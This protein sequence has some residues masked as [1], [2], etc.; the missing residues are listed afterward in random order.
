MNH[1]MN[2]I[3]GDKFSH[4]AND[5]NVITI[6]K[7]IQLI[8]SNI[9]NKKLSGEYF[10]GQGISN[11][12]EDVI[13]E[14]IN[15][16][17]PNNLIK[18]HFYSRKAN[19]AITHKKN[20]SNVMISTPVFIS[21]N[22][23]I[24]D[25][26][27]DD[28]CAEMSD[29]VTGCHIQGMILIEAARQMMLSVSEI[30]FLDET[31]KMYFILHDINTVFKGFIFPINVQILYKVVESKKKASGAFYSLVAV[32]FHQANEL[33]T[34]VNIGFTAYSKDFMEKKE[35]ILANKVIIDGQV[36]YKPN[37]IID[38]EVD[39]IN[40]IQPYNQSPYTNANNQMGLR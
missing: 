14:L 28:E 38:Q 17:N 1:L 2:Y 25:L 27:I 30:F 40:S 24:S 23:Y 29:H 8:K 16:Y 3:V 22:L 26:C 34:I 6:S 7:F 9:F 31:Q 13:K 21:N 32:E 20:P 36:N 19:K 37:S 12:E 11:K 33:K 4:F 15:N 35:K 5:D 39:I 18:V 10:L